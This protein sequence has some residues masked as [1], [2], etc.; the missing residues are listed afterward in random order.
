[1]KGQ[2]EKQSKSWRKEN[3]SHRKF[4]R[5]KPVLDVLRQDPNMMEVDRCGDR[6][7]C[8]NCGEMDHIT[9]RCFKPKKERV[10]ARIVEEA[11][12]DFSLGRE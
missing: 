12:E 3:S 9:A 6:R 1:M 7:R 2:E 10:E 5:Q 4:G 11:R 8:Y